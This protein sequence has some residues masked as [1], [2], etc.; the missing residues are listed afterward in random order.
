MNT[1]M[2]FPNHWWLTWHCFNMSMFYYSL[3]SK[4]ECCCVK[5]DWVT[6]AEQI[7]CVWCK[8]YFQVL[9]WWLEIRYVLLLFADQMWCSRKS[10]EM[11]SRGTT[12]L[13]H[14]YVHAGQRLQYYINTLINCW[15][16]LKYTKCCMLFG[17]FVTGRNVMVDRH[18]RA[19]TPTHIHMYV[20]TNTH[21][22]THLCYDIADCFD[23]LHI[24]SNGF[25][26][27]NSDT[28]HWSVDNKQNRK[29][30]YIRSCNHF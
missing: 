15:L 21:T 1:I 14:Q 29:R 13:Y 17:H 8:V 22:H 23:W 2:P 10:T 24:T 28:C 26:C 25:S 18:T 7:S 16:T 12:G 11:T 19:H 9:F 3:K 6:Q 4:H 5:C 27:P 20:H 30:Q